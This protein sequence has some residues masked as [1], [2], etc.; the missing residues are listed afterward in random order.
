MSPLRILILSDGRPGHYHLSEGIAAAIG[1]RRATEII[2]TD[3]RRRGPGRLAAMLVNR[4][5]PPARVL[6]LIHGLD[7][8]RVPKVDLIVSAGAET[9]AAN[10]SLA[11]LTG[12]LN[13]F[14]GSLRQFRG[15]DFS[16]VLS[17]YAQHASH[18]RV[19]VALKPSPLDPDTLRLQ[20]RQSRP[21]P[22]RPPG[23]AGLLIGGDAGGISYRGSDWKKLLGFLEVSHETLGMRWVV[24]NSRRTA[25]EVSDALTGWARRR[26]GP[27]EAFIDVRG[28]GSGTLAQVFEQAEM[29]LVTDDSS[30]MV[31]EAIWVR[32]PVLGV[33]PERCRFTPEEQ[34]Y[35][36]FLAERGWY[37]S[38]PIAALT[39]D[40][41]LATISEVVPLA[42][43]PLDRLAGLLSERLPQLF[44]EGVKQP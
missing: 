17:S 35:R 16:L 32:R 12:A 15:E 18:P 9:L 6:S 5:T 44:A 23:I 34:G 8:Q 43:N 39:P 2:R 3:V 1:R 29:V 37:R 4:G 27:I 20:G 38:L 22:D 26:E 19:A 42:E 11:K 24:S 40:Q 41:V 7:H 10:I 14:Y 33:A 25:P 36:T 31:S 28:A 30:S 21:G 13:I